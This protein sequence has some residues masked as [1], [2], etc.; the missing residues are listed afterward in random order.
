MSLLGG[1]WTVFQQRI[2]GTLGFDK[3]WSTYRKGFGSM[4]GNF[5]LGN[6]RLHN[7]TWSSSNDVLFELVDPMDRTY[8]P[9]YDE[10]KVG[11][12]SDQYRLNVGSSKDSGI[13]LPTSQVDGFA[14][15]NGQPFSTIENGS[16]ACSAF[17]GDGGWWFNNCF[18]VCLN[19]YYGQQHTTDAFDGIL[20]L[21]ITDP[22]GDDTHDFAF[23]ATRIMFRKK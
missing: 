4:D 8:Y 2:D 15:H 11:P 13:G 10:F 12:K 17:C 16:V 18:R 21:S 19:G 1:G 6:D 22:D 20:W 23:T 3:D 7:M 9:M 5:W 14:L